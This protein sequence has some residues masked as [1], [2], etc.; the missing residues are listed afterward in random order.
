MASIIYNIFFQ[1]SKKHLINKYTKIHM[2]RLNHLIL[3]SFTENIN[4]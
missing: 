2:P 1:E 4:S 3:D